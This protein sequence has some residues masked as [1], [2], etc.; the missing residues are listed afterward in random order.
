MVALTGIAVP[1]GLSFVLSPMIGASSL[2]AFAAGAALCA[3][4]LGTTF[5]LLSTSG[6][7]SSRLGVV[8]TSAAMM[9]DVVGL[10]MVQVIS[11]L[12]TSSAFDA[13]TVVRPVFVS[14]G[15]A[16][17]LPLFCRFIVMPITKLIVRQRQAKPSSLMSRLLRK[18]LTALALYTGI[19]VGIVAGATYAGSSAL[20][21]AYIAGAMISW[22]DAE[23]PHPKDSMPSS[24]STAEGSTSRTGEVELP[25]TGE[26]QGSVRNLPVEDIPMC[27][28]EALFE[29]YYGPS[30]RRVFKP[31]FFVSIFWPSVP[32]QSLI[33]T[34]ASVGF[35]IPITKMF[36]GSIVWRG[37]VYTLLMMIGKLVCG[38][39]LLRMPNPFVMPKQFAR[40]CDYILRRNRAPGAPKRKKDRKSSTPPEKPLSIYPGLILGSAMVARGEIGYLISSLAEAGD[41]FR[42]PAKRDIAAS[43]DPTEA[44]L[45]ITWA[46]TLCTIAG[47]VT[48]GLLVGRVRRLEREV[49][50]D[51]QQRQRANVLGSWG[52][53]PSPA[54]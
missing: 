9:D 52:I 29:K 34:Q 44:F 7:S 10:I 36:T 30:L 42:D 8:L 16:V 54:S 5:T 39:W 2:Q 20:L 6:L 21:G 46:I 47:P 1:M 12:G 27:S 48:M 33:C 45:I 31:L 26:A 11:N 14:L 53:S 49:S 32:A 4:S 51:A 35:S 13:V 25:P 24:P 23:A 17:L 40:V 37:L 15:L 3:T 28:G 18:E 19:L 50:R 41:V 38:L 22:W 43:N